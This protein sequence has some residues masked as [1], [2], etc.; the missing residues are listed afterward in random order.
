[1][2]DF[3]VLKCFPI[4]DTQVKA[5]CPFCEKWHTHNYN[6]DLKEGRAC[7]MI[8]HCPSKHSAFEYGYRL[9][10]LTKKEKKELMDNMNL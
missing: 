4:S 8:A 2:S 5:W 1:M 6:T 7:H 9:S 10:P 3:P